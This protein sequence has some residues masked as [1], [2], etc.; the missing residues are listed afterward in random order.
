MALIK[1][2]SLF[3]V[4]KNC[5]R[6]Y[7]FSFFFLLLI[8]IF[9]GC[10]KKGGL[11]APETKLEEFPL[12]FYLQNPGGLQGNRYQVKAQIDRQLGWQPGIGRLILI[13]ATTASGLSKKVPVFFPDNGG[14]GVLPGQ[15][16]IMTVLVAEEN[17]ITVEDYEK[18]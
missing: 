18:Y 3:I 4:L 10:G 13:Q 14:P 11:L 2:D 17:L 9:S 16:F 8:L 1:E 6:R 12:A 5:F 15:K 7:C